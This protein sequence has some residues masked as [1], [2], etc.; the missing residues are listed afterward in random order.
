MQ[1]HYTPK[2]AS[3]LN[4]AEIEIGS[5]S[6]QCL[7]R[8]IP[9]PKALQVEVDAWQRERNALRRTMDWKFIRQDADG[10]LGR[11]YVPKLAC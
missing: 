3:W 5:L 2:H 6:R 9:T 11:H 1:F 4:M 10:K 8:R 7:N